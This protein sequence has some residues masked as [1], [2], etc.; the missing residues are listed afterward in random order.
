[1]KNK[2][3]LLG[4][5]G[6][7]GKHFTKFI[8]NNELDKLYS[9]VGYDII[10]SPDACIP[11]KIADLTKKENIE[12]II[13]TERPD[14]IINLIAKFTIDTFEELHKI[15]VEISENIF[16][17]LIA[18]NISPKKILIIGSAAEY[19][20][21]DCLPIS[22]DAHLQAINDYSK[23]KILQTEIAVENYKKHGLNCVIARP[24][25]IFSYDMP[26]S[27]SL[28]SFIAQINKI[29]E[30]GTIKVG[31]LNTKRDFVMVE[32]AVSAMWKILIYGNP[33]EAYNI[34]SG[35]SICIHDFLDYLILKSGKQI[36]VEIDPARF[37]VV[38]IYDSYGDN[39]KL[40]NQLNW[41]FC[42]IEV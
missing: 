41:S 34:C 27:L 20:K 16:S 25:N 36:N 42:P 35:R 30:R 13:S 17:S 14:Y 37:K 11:V 22:E 15:N 1:M 24:F 39:S 33:G 29:E 7:I 5:S 21:N 2:I 23:T 4:A 3:L 32:D 18:N 28:G 38:D 31:N 26:Q 8:K 40:V 9:F 19:G 6:F 12:L 10:E